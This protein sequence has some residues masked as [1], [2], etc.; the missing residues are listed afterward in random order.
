M[1]S[2]NF[3]VFFGK[4]DTFD[5]DYNPFASGRGKTQFSNAGFVVNPALFRA[6]PYS[7]LGAGFLILSDE[8]VPIF[9]F[10]VLNPTDTANRSGFSE[11]FEEGV[12]LF[13]ELRLSSNFFDLPGHH[14]F[15]GAW[16][17]RDFV[18]L[19]QDPRIIFPQVPIRP[20][21]GNWGLY[22][23]GAQYLCVDECD[24]TKGWGVFA[25][26]GA[27]DRES[28]LVEYFL[29]AG[30][31]GNSMIPGRQNDTFGI[32]WF[33]S[34]TSSEIGPILTFLFGDIGD[35]D[36]LEAYYNIAVTPWLRITPDLQILN[37][38]LKAID[39]TV[40]TGVRGQVIF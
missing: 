33:R 7:T 40:V 23:N 2:P 36:G 11:L 19:G 15:G 12:S 35:S 28:H 21:T 1:L 13:S 26:A 6:A 17:S 10:N 5:G 32:G 34:Y 37:P 30:I 3:G 20:T 39:T 38:G 22:W 9:T 29:S 27:A 4:L 14:L 8:G 24:P 25:R 16:N 18:A 31:G